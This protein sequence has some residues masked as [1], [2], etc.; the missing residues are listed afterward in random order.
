MKCTDCKKFTKCSA[1]RRVNT[2]VSEKMWTS[3]FWNN[4]ESICD[5][6]DIINKGNKK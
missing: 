5:E 1:V 4:A 6:F 2:D 3:E